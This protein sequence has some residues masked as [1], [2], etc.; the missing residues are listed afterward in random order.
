MA[1][2]GTTTTEDYDVEEKLIQ[3][4]TKPQSSPPLKWK[5][6]GYW[7]DSYDFIEKNWVALLANSF[8]WF[9]FA[10]FAYLVEPISQN[11]AAGDHIIVWFIFS[12]AFLCRPIGGSVIGSIGDYFGRKP[13]F[14]VASICVVA[15]TCLQGAL[16]TYIVGG[17][18]WGQ[19]GLALL[20]IL[21][22]TQGIGIGGEVGSGIIYLM[23]TS[24]RRYVGMTMGWLGVSGGLG[25]L[26][27]SMVAATLNSALTKDQMNVWGWRI[28][29]LVAI[30]PGIA[31][32]YLLNGLQETEIFEEEVHHSHHHESGQ[33]ASQGQSNAANKQQQEQAGTEST[34]TTESAG[35][36]EV[37]INS[38]Q[39]QAQKEQSQTRH[40][41]HLTYPDISASQGA[42]RML[43]LFLLLAGAASWWYVGCVYV[44][45]WLKEISGSETGYLRS[46]LLWVAVI[47]N[48]VSLPT[49]LYSGYLVDRYGVKFT[50]PMIMGAIFLTGLPFFAILYTTQSLAVIL[51]GPGLIFGICGGAIGT[52]TSIMS[53]DLFPPALRHRALGLSYNLSICMFGGLGPAW[54]ELMRPTLPL[55]G[56]YFLA[57]TAAV[58][59]AT[60]H[61]YAEEMLPKT[62]DI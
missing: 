31:V 45:D 51:I 9:E 14:W 3:R 38:E 16:P 5:P 20:L 12:L 50:Y 19:T 39:E 8:E 53:S 18:K 25:F 58:S 13:A 1:P 35:E 49:A 46:H 10:T 36:V 32:L 59:L 40:R 41:T 57:V 37:E 28:P 6:E 62:H 23:E 34:Q 30:I 17:E 26:M 47:Q 43:V 21:R 44:F 48:V 24:A 27:A 55:A 52:A 7:S 15:S 11:F 33:N 42:F 60:Y 61:M 4:E 29:F 56:G 22:I 54:V 2:Q